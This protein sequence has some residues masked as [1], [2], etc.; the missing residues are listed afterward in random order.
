MK[1][2]SSSLAKLPAPK[3]WDELVASERKLGI[4]K[5][6]TD[7]LENINE[8]SPWAL[9]NIQQMTELL[10]SVPCPQCSSDNCLFVV[11]PGP[12]FKQG[13]VMGFSEELCIKC[14]KCTYE[15][16]KVHSSPRVN[17]NPN[18]PFVINT[19]MTYATH[20]LGKGHDAMDTLCSIVGLHPL[21]KNAFYSR[22]AEI[23]QAIN[24]AY[25]GNPTHIIHLALKRVLAPLDIF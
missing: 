13:E 7:P 1:P 25:L 4:M 11:K 20:E 18:S 6:M 12:D 5:S 8:A 19:L 22:K 23:E 24:V 2:G 17:P 3:S 21:Q 16:K 9:V 15:G 10:S 14:Q